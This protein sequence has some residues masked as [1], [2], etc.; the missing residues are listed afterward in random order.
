MRRSGHPSYATGNS[1]E[2]YLHSVWTVRTDTGTCTIDV[3][4]MS[5]HGG[6]HVMLLPSG[7]S[8]VRFM[9]AEDYEVRDTVRAAELY[10]SSCR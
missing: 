5:G 7:L 4:L 3:P 9:D 2:R 6:N 10:R 1:A 8:I